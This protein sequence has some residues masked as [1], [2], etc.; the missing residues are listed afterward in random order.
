MTPYHIKIDWIDFNTTLEADIYKI[1]VLD[2]DG[3][4][5]MQKET[6]KHKVPLELAKLLGVANNEKNS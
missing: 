3:N 6:V 1:S 4:V 5:M 2:K